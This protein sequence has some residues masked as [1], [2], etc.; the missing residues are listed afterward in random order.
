MEAVTA[1]WQLLSS[2]RSGG[3]QYTSKVING[4]LNNHPSYVSCRDDLMHNTHHRRI[5]DPRSEGYG[6]GREGKARL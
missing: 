3:V 4:K 2:G 1:V 5:P 6:Y